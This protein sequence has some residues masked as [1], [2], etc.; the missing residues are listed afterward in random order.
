MHSTEVSKLEGRWID[1]RLGKTPFRTFA[2]Q[3]LASRLGIRPR[4]RERDNSLVRNHLVYA[5]GDVPI[6]RVGK[7]D[8]QQWVQGM[9]DAGYSPATVKKT[10]S[11]LG[12]I[13]AEAVDH[14]LIPETPCR[15]ISLPRQEKVERRYLS[16]AEIERLIDAL[17][18]AHC[19]L[20][21]VAA[22]LG[23]RWEELSG[24]RRANLDLL[25]RQ[26]RVV[27][28]IERTAGTYRYVE[29]TKSDAGRRTLRLPLFIVE[30]LA[31]H[32]EHA[33][34]SEWVFPASEGGFLRYDNFRSRVWR[35]AVRAAGLE[36][37][38]FHELRHTAAAIMVD[39]GADPLQVSRRL[40][41]RDVRTTLGLYGHLFPN[42]EDDLN[43]GLER[44]FLSARCEE[45]ATAPPLAIAP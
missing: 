35:P 1:P 45:K 26:L 2:E 19:A 28:S 25:R 5:F 44:A 15:R 34:S 3:W 23:A 33:P 39:Q 13:M 9:S 27:G 4:T 12:A 40:G 32:L 21:Y 11:L 7:R 17:P 8:V 18:Q 36:P 14:R 22:Y 6:A 41:H 37:L 10:F 29:E 42:R 31:R 16:P 30:I 24:L 38:T 20:G 43:D